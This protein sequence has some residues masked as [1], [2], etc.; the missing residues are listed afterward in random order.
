MIRI[1]TATHLPTKFE[2]DCDDALFLKALEHLIV[3]GNAHS[4]I[5]ATKNIHPVSRDHPLGSM[6][7][8]L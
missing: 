7:C 3:E 4:N 2:D 6:V 5:I 1:R 8:F